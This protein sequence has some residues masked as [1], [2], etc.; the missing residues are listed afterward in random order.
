MFGCCVML[1]RV[2]GFAVTLSH[3]PCC[4]FSSAERLGKVAKITKRRMLAHSASFMDWIV[5]LFGT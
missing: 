4:S 1:V 3:D 5:Q 2:V